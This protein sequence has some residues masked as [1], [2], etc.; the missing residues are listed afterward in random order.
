[1]RGY[2][3]PLEHPEASQELESRLLLIS[4]STVHGTGYLDHCES[5]IQEFLGPVRQVLF[6]PFAAHDLDTYVVRVRERLGRMG[7]EVASLHES[8]EPR[9]S[10]RAAE[11]VFIGGGNTF[12]LL[13]ALYDQE[14][15]APLRSRV[16]GGTPYFGA[17]AGAN[18]AGATIKTT[19]DMPIV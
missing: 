16:A 13:K 17:S 11:A 14:L 2:D 3:S 6:V 4:S 15:I 8:G 12:R 5:E 1:S 18:V 7:L 9:E 19:N 10:I